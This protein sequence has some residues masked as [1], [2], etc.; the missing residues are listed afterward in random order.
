MAACRGLAK[1]THTSG[2]VDRD[3]HSTGKKKENKTRER[4]DTENPVSNI[5]GRATRR[6]A[7]RAQTERLHGRR[8]SPP[9]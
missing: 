9:P 2:E 5:A 4:A 7:P 3:R 8:P 1:R 6:S